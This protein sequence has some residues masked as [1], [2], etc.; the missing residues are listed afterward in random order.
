M[1]RNTVLVCGL[2][3]SLGAALALF[4]ENLRAEGPSDI[5]A[6]AI[7]R[8]TESF[9]GDLPASEIRFNVTDPET[10]GRLLSSIAFADP[11]NGKLLKSKINAFVYLKSRAGEVQAYEVYLAWQS[12]SHRGRR[13]RSYPVS[14]EGQTL[15][16]T[17]AQ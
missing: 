4:T 6:V 11:R 12:F 1:L 7:Y 17:L 3:V 2:A 16:A 8:S 15:F 9:Q 5:V 14:P 13:E 10:I